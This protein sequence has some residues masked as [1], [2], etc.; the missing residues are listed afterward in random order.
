[1]CRIRQGSMVCFLKGLDAS[2]NWQLKTTKNLFI[3]NKK[4]LQSL[5]VALIKK[6][7]KNKLHAPF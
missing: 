3:I 6:L 5:K 4:K 2:N 7:S 1:M